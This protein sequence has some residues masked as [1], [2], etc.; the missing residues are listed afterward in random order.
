MSKPI[1]PQSRGN[2]SVKFGK[3]Q[4]GAIRE[5]RRVSEKLFASENAT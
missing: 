1:R 2:N 4:E 3:F 5:F